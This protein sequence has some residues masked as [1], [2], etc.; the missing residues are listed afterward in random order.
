MHLN[1]KHRNI[2]NKALN[3]YTMNY[4]MCMITV[5]FDNSPPHKRL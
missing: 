2:L 5:C 3:C 4:Q 1:V